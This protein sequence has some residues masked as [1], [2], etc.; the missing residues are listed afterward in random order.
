MFQ[1]V[2]YA[3]MYVEQY[4]SA[5]KSIVQMFT[6]FDDEDTLDCAVTILV[7]RLRLVGLGKMHY[8]SFPGST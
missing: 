4:P 8:P 5:D 6:N 7:L 2:T 1:N 3:I